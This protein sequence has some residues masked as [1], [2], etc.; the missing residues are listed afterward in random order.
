MSDEDI[1]KTKKYRDNIDEFKIEE[2]LN[3]KDSIQFSDHEQQEGE[4]L[5]SQMLGNIIGD[6]WGETYT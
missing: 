6:N 2:K 5:D 3:T 4:D 1:H